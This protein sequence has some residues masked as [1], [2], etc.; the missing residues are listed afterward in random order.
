MSQYASTDLF[1]VFDARRVKA[2]ELRGLDLMVNGIVGWFKNRRPVLARLKKMAG[3]I[4]TLEPEIHNLGST[5]FQEEV[6]AIRDQ[7][8]LGKMEGAVLERGVALAREA[9][10]RSL[11]KRPYP[12]QVM[13]ALAM[14]EG[15]I[16][17]MATGEGKTITAAMGAA[18]HAFAG[19]PVHVITVNDYL[20]A[21]DAEEMGPLYK[22]LGNTCGHVIHDC[23]P[24]MRYHEYRKN[25][26]YV[27]SKELVA[28]FLRDQI[29]LGHVRSGSE[30]MIQVLERGQMRGGVLVPGLWRV[31]VDEADSLLIDEAVT[32]L[33]ISNS[34][35][36][37]PNAD[38]YRLATQLASMLEEGRDFTV[39]RTVRTVDLTG[40]G[41]RH[42]DDLADEMHAQLGD[43]K[44]NFFAGKR[45]REE[46][47]QQAL[48]ARHCFHRDEHYL[49]DGE[50]KVQIIDE[51]TG[52]VMADRTW[53]HGLHQAIEVKE[54]VPVTADKENLA[55][56][57]F[58]RFFRQYPIMAG[59][60]GTA[61]ES[62]AELWQIYQR[63]V[64]RIP[65]NKP[66]IRKQLKARM[67]DTAEQKWDA[68][69]ARVMELNDKGI[70][71]L[72]GTRSVGA[73]E[74][75]SRR[76]FKA[77]RPHRVLNAA[78]NAEEATIVAEAGL[79]GKITVATNMAGRGTDIKLGDGVC[80]AGGLH[81]IATE[82]HGSHRVDRQLFGRAARQGDPGCAQMF[83]SAQD[84]LFV[85]YAPKLRHAWRALGFERL[86]KH[87]QAKAERFARFNRKQVLKSDEWMDQALP[88]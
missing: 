13:G 27:T 83:A 39:D 51:S 87:A 21:R 60:T 68:V 35:D 16:A 88:F 46:L 11:D 82:P 50:G 63:P 65:T 77:G 59:M 61:W 6:Q 81:V 62:A 54:D 33:I 57:S 23:P 25:V 71:V 38:L 32:P 4:E 45:R 36:D 85:R 8:R 14:F 74:E 78:Q 80:E 76:L 53:R 84:D 55:R 7:A 22:M 1:E 20:V 56:Q 10:W 34:P 15:A 48:V 26:V 47:V 44:S 72:V 52:R 5:R 31:I 41:H 42:L 3:R 70:P 86:R 37:N 79:R 43:G 64:I 18:L 24:D 28:D 2:P 75:V 58:Q 49:I 30:Q 67:F 73:S 9:C 19:R 12:V 66:C 17:E 40:R 69:V 29:H